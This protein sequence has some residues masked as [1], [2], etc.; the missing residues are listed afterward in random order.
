MT[1]PRYTAHRRLGA[2]VAVVLMA[3]A[4]PAILPAG[5]AT[6]TGSLPVTAPAAPADATTPVL[7]PGDKVLGMGRTGFLSQDADDFA[8][9]H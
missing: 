5:A 7:K 6:G 8:L 3:T 9:R 4:G 1:R 2:V